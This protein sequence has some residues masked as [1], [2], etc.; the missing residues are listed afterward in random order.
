MTIVGF[1]V[2]GVVAIILACVAAVAC[3]D[4]IAGTLTFSL[5]ALCWP[6]F[7]MCLL[8]VSPALLG[9]GVGRTIVYLTRWRN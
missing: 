5:L 1:A 6:A 8:L 7:A 2:W 4:D 3:K 9:V